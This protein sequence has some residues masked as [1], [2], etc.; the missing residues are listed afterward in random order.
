LAGP[1]SWTM[2]I[3]GFA[4]GFAAYRRKHKMALTAA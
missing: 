2:M 4:G 3:L 1:S